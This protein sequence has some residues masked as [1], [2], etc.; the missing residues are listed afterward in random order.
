MALLDEISV[1]HIRKHHDALFGRPG[2]GLEE[3]LHIIAS[4]KRRGTLVGG[5]R[6]AFRPKA[7]HAKL[8]VDWWKQCS[9]PADLQKNCRFF[10]D[11]PGF[12]FGQMFEFAFLSDEATGFACSFL[13]QRELAGDFGWLDTKTGSAFF[14]G[15]SLACPY[16]AMRYLDIALE[17]NEP[18][19]DGLQSIVE[20]LD[21]MALKDDLFE[22]AAVKLLALANVKIDRWPGIADARESFVNLFSPNAGRLAQSVSVVDRAP[23]LSIMLLRN[24]LDPS[25]V[26]G[27][28]ANAISR[29]TL[30]LVAN[31][32]VSR[33]MMA[34]P[35]RPRGTNKDFEPY[36][37]YWQHLFD[38]LPKLAG[39][40]RQGAMTILLASFPSLASLPEMRRPIIKALEAIASFEDVPSRELA[41]AIDLFH[42]SGTVGVQRWFFDRLSALIALCAPNGFSD[43]TWEDGLSRQLVM[44]YDRRK[45]REALVENFVTQRAGHSLSNEVPGI[46]LLKSIKQRERPL[47]PAMARRSY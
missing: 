14:Y 4:M 42:H 35:P 41:R 38:I 26:L 44:R 18:I 19:A 34:A 40:R 23:I 20:A 30:S 21:S 47:V 22:E 10:L 1:E 13:K 45:V 27:A 36:L 8:W 17:S 6:L 39:E 29:Q 9:S 43:E 32:G 7:L 31:A 37:T 2:G 33:E 3:T 15:L 46:A 25:I 5:N 28:F 16:A 24:D 12:A 11:T